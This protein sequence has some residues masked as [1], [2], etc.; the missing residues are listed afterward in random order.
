MARERSTWA[1]TAKTEIPNMTRKRR[2]LVVITQ[3]VVQE[4]PRVKSGKK[5]TRVT[6]LAIPVL[7]TGRQ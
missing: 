1:E 3:I 2:A 7:G 4:I 5:T 6:M